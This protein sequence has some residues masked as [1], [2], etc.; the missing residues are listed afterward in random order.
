MGLPGLLVAAA[1][2]LIYDPGR[3]A[4]EGVTQAGKADRYKLKDY[5]AV[6]RIEPFSSI[7]LAW[8]L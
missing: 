2:L 6:F 7:P 1:G 8:P 3:G 5:L 4:S